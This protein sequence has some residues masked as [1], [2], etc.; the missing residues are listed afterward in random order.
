MID[1]KKIL[2][3]ILLA[4]AV[5]LYVLYA[6][7]FFFKL[8]IITVVAFSLKEFMALALPRHPS[9]SPRLGIFLGVFLSAVLLFARQGSELWMGSLALISI[10]T[11]V[12]YLFA[13]QDLHIVLSQIAITVFGCVYVSGLFSYVGLIR[14][15]SHGT[16]WIFLVAGTTFMA[17]SCAYF[18][19]HVLGRHKLAPKI[20]PGKTIEGLLGGILGSIFAAFVCRALFWQEFSVSSCIILGILVGLVGPLGDLSE[21]LIKRSV[22]IK[23][24]GQL[25]PGHGGLLDRLDAL[26][27][28]APLV[29]YYAIFFFKV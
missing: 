28:T 6:P 5:I 13:D 16:F 11:F 8:L 3:G 20:S 7:V 12:Y 17:D 4:I 14:T 9:S 19:G 23:D 26:L 18:T 29:Y 2:W 24:S 27:F 15:L 22:G 25:I 21:S 1:T 10:I